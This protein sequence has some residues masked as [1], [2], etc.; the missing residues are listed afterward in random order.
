M[1]G[2]QTSFSKLSYHFFL[3]FVSSGTTRV[4]RADEYDIGLMCFFGLLVMIPQTSL[5]KNPCKY[6]ER[7]LIFAFI[8]SKQKR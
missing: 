1:E 2:G 6:Q 4:W 8:T 3:F 7:E 5:R